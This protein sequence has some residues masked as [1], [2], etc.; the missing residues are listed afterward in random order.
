MH[1]RA[2]IAAA[3]AVALSSTTGALAQ[4][5]C[6]TLTGENIPS[7]AAVAG[8]E[9]N[10]AAEYDGTTATQCCT[11]QTC[12]TASATCPTGYSLN[13]AAPAWTTNQNQCCTTKTC[14]GVT[15]S[16]NEISSGL[17]AWTAAQTECC[18]NKYLCS[19]AAFDDG[20]YCPYGYTPKTVNAVAM[21][22]PATPTVA[23]C[24]ERDTG[25][26]SFPVCTDT[27]SAGSTGLQAPTLDATSWSVQDG[28]G[29]VRSLNK[30]KGMCFSVLV[31]DSDCMSDGGVA[32]A[33]CSS[34][35]PT[36][37]QVKLPPTMVTTTGSKNC[38]LSYGTGVANVNSLKRITKWSTAGL[39]TSSEAKFFNVPITWKKGA[40]TATVCLYSNYAADPACTFEKICGV[41]GTVPDLNGNYDGGCEL[42]IVGRKV[43]GS[44]ACCAPTFSVESFDSNSENRL[45]GGGEASSS[46]TIDIVT[47]A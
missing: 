44:S 28:N 23:L 9:F 13:P 40:K 7:C 14:T 46:A 43:S 41:D 39:G 11:K 12:G 22:D 8:F 10:S 3:L 18:V 45:A 6:S 33:C 29:F 32:T 27:S 47:K 25:M 34:R 15:C 38:R 30:Y 17:S 16:A 4:T 19:N 26:R 35:R 36:F 21:K 20:N 24:C 5:A 37:V 31:D 2:A 42:R 1:L